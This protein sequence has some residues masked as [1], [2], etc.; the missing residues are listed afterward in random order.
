MPLENKLGLTDEAALARAEEKISKTKALE[1]YDTGLLDAFPVGTFAG[2]QKIHGYLFGEIYPFAGQMRTV[3]IA[4]GNFRFAPVIWLRRWKASMPCP[5]LPLMR[6]S[7]S[8]W[9]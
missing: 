9:R 1:L 5:S 2:L 8:M 7:K 3:N 4:K 6:S